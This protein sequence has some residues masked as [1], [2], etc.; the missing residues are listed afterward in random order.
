MVVGTTK[1][2][3]KSIG[4]YSYRQIR[5]IHIPPKIPPSIDDAHLQ[6]SLTADL[7]H[8]GT[9]CKAAR[10][11]TAQKGDPT[12]C[13]QGLG[14]ARITSREKNQ[15]NTN[16]VPQPNITHSRR[17]QSKTD[18]LITPIWRTHDAA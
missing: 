3:Q 6:P 18:P 12:R 16:S 7:R 8:F 11:M 14:I 15:P 9:G 17:S 4:A 13:A 2:C 10:P 1:Q 5:K